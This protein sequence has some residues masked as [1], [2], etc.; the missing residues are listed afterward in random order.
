MSEF[1]VIE[2]AIRNA[3][4]DGFSHAEILTVATACVSSET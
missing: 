4:A 1:S 3:V 2:H